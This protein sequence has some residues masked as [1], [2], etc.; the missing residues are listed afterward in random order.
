MT[1]TPYA[2]HFDT[3]PLSWVMGEIRDALKR[4]AVSLLE[5]VEKDAEGRDGALKHAKTYLHQAH[6]ALQMVDVDGDFLMTQGAEEAID[7]F[8][9]GALACTPEHVAVL[10]DAYQAVTEYLEELLSG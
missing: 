10:A 3:G 1:H 5:A 6:G 2:A 7:R 9:S 8:K 4:S